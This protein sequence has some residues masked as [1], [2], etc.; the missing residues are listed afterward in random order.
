MTVRSLINRG[1]LLR[2]VAAAGLV[3][4][5]TAVAMPGSA[6]AAELASGRDG[7]IH[8]G[9]KM[10][11]PE[12][13]CTAN[14][15]FKGDGKVYIGQ[16]AH[17]TGTGNANE[18]DGCTSKSLPLGTEI[19]IQGASKP[20]KLAYNSWLTMQ[21]NGEKDKNTCSYNDF[22]L[23]QVDEDDV[24]K[25]NPAVPT[26]GG[27]T[28]VRERGLPAGATVYSYQQSGLRQGQL[29]EKQGINLGDNGGGWT[30]EVAT[31]TPG[32][33]GD[34]GSGFLDS[35][36]RA[37]GLLST[38]NLAPAPGT[39]GVSDLGKVLA[40]ANKNGAK[41]SL[42]NGGPFHGSP[43]PELPLAGAP[44][45]DGAQGVP[46]AAQAQ[47]AAPGDVTVRPRRNNAPEPNADKPEPKGLL[48]G[49]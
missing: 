18:T 23:V 19:K 8:P 17:C 35:D 24:S 39:N 44:V 33:P 48:G 28:G 7:T 13:Q 34:S 14:F 31:L 20:G 40:Y 9:V 12:G 2:C 5:A 1:R 47:E 46:N 26:F 29:S 11:S 22:A 32:V 21:K 30:H 16:A 3:I 41:V 25:V 15:V 10:Q 49:F 37:F 42:V 45:V 43:L 36:G 4:G 38:L 6:Q 27:P